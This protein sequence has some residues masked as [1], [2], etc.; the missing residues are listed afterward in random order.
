MN[1]QLESDTCNLISDR[2]WRFPQLLPLVLS[3]VKP[4]IH[5]DPYTGTSHLLL[6]ARH[7]RMEIWL[8][9]SLPPPTLEP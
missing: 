8:V 5:P 7:A 9:L 1:L 4:I 2:T 3:S 6:H